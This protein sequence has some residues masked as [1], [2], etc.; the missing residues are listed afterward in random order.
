MVDYQDCIDT[1]NCQERILEVTG[2][3]GVVIFNLYT[4][5]TA[6]IAT[7]VHGSTIFQND[8]NQRG[9]TTEDS[10]W[11]PI[12]GADNVD[13]VY[14]GTPIWTSTTVTCSVASCLL[15]FP[16]SHLPIPTTI[17]PGNY[18]T[19]F[20]YG[21]KSQVTSNGV[22]TEIFI[23]T[24]TTTVLQITS[25]VV[26]GMG[27][28][29]Y[30]ITRGETSFVISESVD[31]PS[32]TIGLPDGSGGTTSRVVP[33]PPWPQIIQGPTVS[34]SSAQATSG[35]SNTYYTGLTA[36]I[37]V[38]GP[39]VTTVSFATTIPPT[40]V[41]CPPDSKYIPF[42]AFFNSKENFDAY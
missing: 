23:T 9:F 1:F 5:A 14:V 19:S 27:Y 22:T 11:L 18:T 3:T 38:N 25:I 36:T 42:L 26:T 4:V 30:N 39:T 35:V 7:G 6:E 21:T 8:T 29:N 37:S 34:E 24:T 17:T 10:I 33:L 40:T 41:S 13:T 12:P 31:I 20:E 15:V 2:S 28:S 32:T 16:T